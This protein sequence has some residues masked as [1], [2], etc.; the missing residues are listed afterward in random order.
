MM[1][2]INQTSGRFCME[3]MDGTLKVQLGKVVFNDS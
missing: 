2:V 1:V 3:L